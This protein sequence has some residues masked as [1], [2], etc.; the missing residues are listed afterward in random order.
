MA[1]RIFNVLFLGTTNSARS[2]IAEA[3]L[4]HIGNGR[5]RAFSA[6]SLPSGVVNPLVTDMLAREGL[7]TDALRS[8]SW[9]EFAQPNAPALDFV[10]TVCDTVAGEICP[11]WPGQPITAHWGIEDPAAIDGDEQARR[12][13]VQMA[14]RRLSHR[15][16]LFVSL[17]FA[18]LDALS[19]RHRLDEIGRLPA[20]E[21]RS[22]QASGPSS[23]G[24]A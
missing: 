11:V 10:I 8:K 12:H 16:V 6:G 5:F 17:P 21:A 2:L 23:S 7:P 13:A 19:L 24:N 22:E 4:N 15:I 1:E 9:E 18:H 20:H 14:L 3:L